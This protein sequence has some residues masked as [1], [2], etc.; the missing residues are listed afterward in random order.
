MHISELIEQLEARGWCES[1]GPERDIYI[2]CPVPLSGLGSLNAL[3]AQGGTLAMFPEGTT[4]EWIVHVDAGGEITAT[5]TRGFDGGGLEV[6][7]GKRP[8]PPCF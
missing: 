5:E 2:F 4:D 8:G 6:L 7:K 3:A 1:F